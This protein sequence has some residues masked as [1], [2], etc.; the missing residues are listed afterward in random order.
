[1]I[2]P[3]PFGGSKGLGSPRFFS[4][5]TAST[6]LTVGTHGEWGDA[7]GR[8][9][10]PWSRGDNPGCYGRSP[11]AGQKYSLSSLSRLK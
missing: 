4:M 1:M 5:A 6:A 8:W 7:R 11:Q 3:F 10:F 2:I 9:G